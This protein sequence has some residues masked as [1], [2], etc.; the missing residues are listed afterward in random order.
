MTF[1]PEKPLGAPAWRIAMIVPGALAAA[2]ESALPDDCRAVSAFEATP[3]GDWTVEG[4][5]LL[6]PDRALLAARVALLAAAHGVPEPSV[7]IIRIPP[8]DWL[9]ETRE[10]FPPLRLGRFFIHGSHVDATSCPPAAI[11]LLV[12]AATAFGTGEHPSTAGCLMALERLDRRGRPR[13]ALD[14]GC[15]SG[16]LALAMAKLWHCP[17]QAADIEAESVRVAQFNARRNGVAALVQAVR[18]NGYRH[19]AI[20]QAG[21]Y[22]LIAANI[23]A[24]PLSAMAAD[25]ARHLAPDGVA[26][27]SGLLRNQEPLVLAAHRLAGLHL[28]DRIIVGP[29]STLVLRR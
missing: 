27:L 29:W 14:M 7:E 17:V 21:P 18:S 15:G 3:D 10:A 23:L 24:R 20:A 26:V 22:D 19:A 9:A 6:E 4:Y 25:L 12:D 28:A 5:A 1:I 2:F 8:T 13:R 11:P 16:I